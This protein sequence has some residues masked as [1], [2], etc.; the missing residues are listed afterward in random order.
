MVSFFLIQYWSMRIPTFKAGLKVFTISQIGDF[1]LFIGLFLLLAL[2]ETSDFGQILASW[3]LW[4]H[5][6]IAIGPCLVSTLGLISLLTTTAMLLK[7]A[8]FVFYP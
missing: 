6:Y 5:T 4:V 1:P 7:A 2:F 3:P 8:Q